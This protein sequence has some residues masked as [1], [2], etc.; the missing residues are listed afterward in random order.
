MIDLCG[1]EVMAA[2]RIAQACSH[3]QKFYR[4]Y[5][6]TPFAILL[7]AG[8]ILSKILKKGVKD[9][10][11]RPQRLRCDPAGVDRR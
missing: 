4:F 7:E 2:R 9:A 3:R 11:D 6:R 1:C 5:Q 10:Q 8:N